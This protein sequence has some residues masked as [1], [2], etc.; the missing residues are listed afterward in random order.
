MPASPGVGAVPPAAQAGKAYDPL[1][2][3][4][5]CNIMGRFPPGAILTLSDG[6]MV[7]SISTVRSPETF[8]APLCRVIRRPDGSMPEGDE[9]LDLAQG[10]TV[11]K[12]HHPKP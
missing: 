8:A 7:L 3:Q 12:V 4:L 6:H 10:G 2:M 11:A 1:L 9:A 5:F